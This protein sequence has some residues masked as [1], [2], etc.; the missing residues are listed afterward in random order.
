M[1]E[2]KRHLLKSP[3]LRPPNY[4]L[5]FYLFTDASAIAYGAAL[6]QSQNGKEMHAEYEPKVIYLEGKANKV[7]DALSREC[8]ICQRNGPNPPRSD[9]EYKWPEAKF[10]F[11]R[12]HADLAGP[13][14]EET[15]TLR[16]KTG[17]LGRP[18]VRTIVNRGKG[19][20]QVLNQE[21]RFGYATSRKNS[22]CRASYSKPSAKGGCG[23]L[24]WKGAEKGRHMWTK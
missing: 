6:M 14:W 24:R 17:P 12:V 4:E 9:P 1:K 23:E 3:C 7:A 22:G 21:T 2:L 11:E 13:I 19:L 15:K 20:N 16:E 10:P 5:E 18:T 8:E